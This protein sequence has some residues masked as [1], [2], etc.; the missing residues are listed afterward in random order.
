LLGT[1]WKTIIKVKDGFNADLNIFNLAGQQNIGLENLWVDVNRRGQTSGNLITF[2]SDNNS[3]NFTVRNCKITDYYIIFEANPSN[4]AV[5]NVLFEKCYVDNMNQTSF[6][7]VSGVGR[8]SGFQFPAVSNI[9]VV[10]CVFTG[11]GQL[12]DGRIWW[13][14]NQHWSVTYS[15]RIINTKFNVPISDAQTH[16]LTV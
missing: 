1:S 11:T 16:C 5:N 14:G 3:T 2:W 15:T 8:N 12:P 4:P 7:F 6:A 9:D 13:W 10:D